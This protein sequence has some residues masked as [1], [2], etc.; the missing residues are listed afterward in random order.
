MY[1]KSLWG[2]LVSGVVG[3]LKPVLSL[4]EVQRKLGPI[5]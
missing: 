5:I 2:N 1:V 4:Y 3:L